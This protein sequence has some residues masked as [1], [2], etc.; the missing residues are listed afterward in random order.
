[1]T[2]EEYTSQLISD[3]SIISI[4]SNVFA[5]SGFPGIIF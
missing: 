5:V 4:V 2:K 1:M 3:V